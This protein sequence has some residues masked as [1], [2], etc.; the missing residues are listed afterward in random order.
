MNMVQKA[1]T[2]AMAEHMAVMPPP[3]GRE[4]QFAS[5]VLRGL[6]A[7]VPEIIEVDP[8]FDYV[9]LVVEVRSTRA[10]VQEVA[11]PIDPEDEPP[12]FE[13]ERV[14]VWGGKPW[15]V[16]QCEHHPLLLLHHPWAVQ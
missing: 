2:A 14:L 5:R 15:T 10:N 4:A 6:E 3:Y 13:D 16:H 1:V 7:V 8:Y 11:I 9:N 12:L